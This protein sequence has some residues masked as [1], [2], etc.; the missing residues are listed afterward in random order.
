MTRVSREGVG[1]GNMG[2]KLKATRWTLQK[3]GE[4]VSVFSEAFKGL[5][6]D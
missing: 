2:K 1:D 6:I 4:D 5:L 3:H